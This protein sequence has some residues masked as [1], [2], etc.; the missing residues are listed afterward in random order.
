MTDTCDSDASS[1]PE[2]ESGVVV[3][4]FES[5]GLYAKLF[6]GERSRLAVVSSRA[7]RA[8]GTGGL[9]FE[10]SIPAFHRWIQDGSSL[11]EDEFAIDVANYAHLHNGPGVFL[12]TAKSCFGLD[13]IGG[14]P[15][16]KYARK[17]G[18][19]GSPTT[20]IAA[21]LARLFAFAERFEA[22]PGFVAAAPHR[23]LRTDALE[24]GIV[25]RLRAPCVKATFDAVSPPL[26]AV[27]ESLTAQQ[28]NLAPEPDPRRPFS[29][30]ARW[31]ETMSASAESF[32]ILRRRAAELEV[33]GASETL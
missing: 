6:F 5:S 29:V 30:C 28:V 17:R 11:G 31:H 21:V 2:G 25:D 33:A 24:F 16:L 7:P 9:D 23:K 12:V 26:S 19:V 20:K 10:A 1:A 22:D 8:T 15:G 14:A 3:A 4:P 18:L 13:A 32:S 27:L